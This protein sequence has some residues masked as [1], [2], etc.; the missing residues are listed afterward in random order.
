MTVC[1]LGNSLTALTLAKALVNQN[2]C[3]DIL[4]N[5]KNSFD[6]NMLIPVTIS[7]DGIRYAINPTDW[8]NKSDI[9]LPWKPNKFL[10][11]VFLGKMKLGSSGE[12]VISEI[13]SITPIV[14]TIIP[15]ISANL[16]IVKLS[17]ELAIFLIF[18]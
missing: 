12:Y 13:N 14:K 1:I 9:K 18:I 8:K 17:A 5:K 11:F 6:L 16:L 4:F 7:V 10:I 15:N 3:V 2:I